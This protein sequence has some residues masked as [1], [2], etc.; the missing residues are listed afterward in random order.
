VFGAGVAVI[1]G[2]AG[3]KEG[4]VGTKKGRTIAALFRV[5]FTDC[6]TTY[7]ARN[8]VDVCGTQGGFPIAALGHIT[9]IGCC[10]T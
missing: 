2:E 5:A 4:V 6:G 8:R 1:A 10:A 9:D 3:D 7:R